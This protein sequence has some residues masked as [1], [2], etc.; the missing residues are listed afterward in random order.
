LVGNRL[1]SLGVNTEWGHRDVSVGTTSL[2]SVDTTKLS[3]H[4]ELTDG[5]TI[6]RHDG[7]VGAAEVGDVT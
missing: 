7:G 3:L 2:D 6:E 5:M 4:M 1:D